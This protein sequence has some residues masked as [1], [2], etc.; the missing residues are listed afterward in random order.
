MDAVQQLNYQP[1]ARAVGRPRRARQAG[2][3]SIGV[4]LAAARYKFSDPYWSPVLDGVDAELRRSGCHLIFAASPE[5]TDDLQRRETLVKGSYDGLILL[6][7]FVDRLDLIEDGRTVVV[8]GE[9]Q[10]RWR[11]EPRVDIVT[12]EKRRS[13]Y[14][15]VDH[16]AMLERRQIGFLGPPAERDERA[17]AFPHALQRAGLAFDPDLVIASAWAI[18]KAYAAVSA[19]LG[20]D[21]KID[22]LICASDELALGAMRAAR[23]RDLRLPQDLAVT[24]FDDVPF[25]ASVHPALTTARL[26]RADVGAVAAQRMIERLDDPGCPVSIQF[27]PTTLIVRASCGETVQPQEFRSNQVSIDP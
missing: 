3:W 27:V 16:L 20:Q 10:L 25:A 15:L 26:S 12:A 14:A 23:E 5:E 6:G 8:E 17:E 11:G 1:F 19:F 13:I 18:D 22:A 7:D 21:P 24:G 4:V 2:P 9:D